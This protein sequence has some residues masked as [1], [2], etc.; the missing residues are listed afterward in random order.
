MNT[1]LRIATCLLAIGLAAPG[2]RA[3]AD[4]VLCDSSFQNCRTPLLTLIENETV[5]IDA[6]FWFMEDARYRT[7][8]IEK[9]K[10][11]VPVRLIIDTEA[12]KKYTLNAEALAAFK[13]AGIPM[14]EKTNSGIVH[15]K[16]ML[17]AGQNVVEFS[18][19]NFSPHAFVFTDPY[20]DYLDEVIYFSDD[21]GVVNSFKTQYDNVWVSTTGYTPYANI[22]APRVRHYEVFPMDSRM[23]F[24]PAQ[25]FATRSVGRYNAEKQKIDSVMFRITDGRHT[26]A[27]IAAMTRGVPFRLITDEQEYRD[28]AFLW[29]SYNV[30]RLHLAAQQLCPATCGVRME[31]H[32]G[33][34]HQKSTLLY[35]QGMTI[36]GSSNWTSA[37]ANR[38]LEHN[39]FTTSPTFFQF[40]A[41]QFERKW[42]NS[43]PIGAVETRP[44]VPLPPDTPV[45]HLPLNGA[46]NQATA[47]NLKWYAGPWGQF[48]D[49][50]LGTDPAN[51]SLIA[52]N[53]KLGPSET[54]SQFQQYA[55]S[56][57][58]MATTYYWKV[59]S[60]T[61]ANVPKS[62][63][64]WSFRTSGA[65]PQAGPLDAVLYAS[66]ASFV[67]GTWTVVADSSAAGGAR[68]ATPNAGAATVGASATASPVNY[69]EMTFLA[70]AGVPY[71]LWVRGKA[72]S[73][74]WANDSAWVQ[75][76]D[77]VNQSGAPLYRIGT[78]SAASVTIEDCA[79]CG[80]SG[81]GWNDNAIGAGVLGPQIFFANSGE[82]TIRVQVREDGLSIDQIVLSRDLFLNTAPGTTKDDGTILLEARGG[83]S[84]EPP[85]PPPPG[86]TDI[87]LHMTG[88]TLAG[89][90][91]MVDDPAAASGK[92]TVLPNAGRAKATAPKAAP[93]DYF[94]LTFTALAN[95]PYRVW[96]RGRADANNGGN[97][98]VY[99]QFTDSVDA[100]GVAVAQIGTTN[101]YAIN[102]EDCGS[103]GNSGW[104]WEDNG[105]GTPETLGPEIRFATDGV[106]TIRIQNREDGFFVDQIVLSPSNYRH[107]APGL[108]KDDSTILPPTP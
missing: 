47:L 50:Y 17:F 55:L 95:T 48:Y 64:V 75:F 49:I 7:A 96:L 69:F 83:T 63:P 58:S 87:V 74:A 51:L 24:P 34:L 39:I 12:N 8:L 104:G 98:S 38:Q 92:A 106:K 91:Q 27:L 15:W 54:A 52:G 76:N 108:N 26:D 78:T 3:S 65:A 19:A 33:S 30:D 62:G 6:A 77:S 70:E 22:T 80:L 99:V 1:F 36:F 40:F 2:A 67:T 21:P 101:G 73:N 37:S 31:A 11:K 103:C 79:S 85:P 89:A 107:V 90:W 13:A 105:W 29:N 14:L 84:G 66:K 86:A 45:Y 35:G 71:R 97:D 68:I 72:A 43:N 94:E 10:A 56:G 100:T 82:H 88:A 59:V 81:W 102:L 16:M 5:G 32:L 46:Q 44:F 23:N 18:G 42:N 28:P 57:L 41:Q 4:D 25:N 20:V 60:K 93:A 9:F 53:I 61:A